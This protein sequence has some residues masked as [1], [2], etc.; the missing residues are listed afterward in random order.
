[1][2]GLKCYQKYCLGLLD[3]IRLDISLAFATYNSLKKVSITVATYGRVGVMLT[4]KAAMFDVCK[5]PEAHELKK[6]RAFK[7]GVVG[8]PG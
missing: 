5:A 3:G 4:I 7:V 1:M 8:S 6:P 2:L